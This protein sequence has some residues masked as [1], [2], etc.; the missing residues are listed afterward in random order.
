MKCDHPCPCHPT[1]L[2]TFR[3]N[4]K[5]AIFPQLM[6]NNNS[7][8]ATITTISNLLFYILPDRLLLAPALP[9]TTGSQMN[10]GERK[11]D[12]LTSAVSPP[13]GR[14]LDFNF[15]FSSAPQAE[16]EDRQTQAKLHIMVVVDYVS[17]HL[18]EEREG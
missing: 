13:L 7:T 2:K 9:S 11:S 1:P 18:T 8:R 10:G 16:E 4:A 5:L 17:P 14:R 15:Y 6:I 12:P 3:V